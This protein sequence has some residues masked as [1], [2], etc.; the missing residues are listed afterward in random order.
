MLT[1]P[2]EIERAQDLLVQTAQKLQTLGEQLADV[3]AQLAVATATIQS[4]SQVSDDPPASEPAANGSEPAAAIAGF[5]DGQWGALLGGALVD[6]PKVATYTR[7]LVRGAR[8]GVQPGLALLAKLMMFRAAC[9]EERLP[10]LREIGEAYYLWAKSLGSEPEPWR[11]ALI[12]WLDGEC[13]SMGLVH[14]I[15]LT[16]VGD[17]FDRNRHQAANTG[18]EIVSVGGWIV[19]RANGSVYT[20]ALVIVS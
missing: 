2:A 7:Q 16:L 20:K 5:F 14:Q 9:G 8:D 15:E 12:A 4:L 18:T 19:L 6:D 11:D 3:S 17:R 13:A 10:L 1:Q